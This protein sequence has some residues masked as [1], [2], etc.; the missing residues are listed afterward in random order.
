ML[1]KLV[2]AICLI[3]SAFGVCAD[4]GEYYDT[5][6]H[7]E[8][9]MLNGNDYVQKRLEELQ[10]HQAK[11]TPIEKDFYQLLSAH[12]DY[13]L[14][15]LYACKEKAKVL[16]KETNSIDIKAKA[17]ILLATAEHVLGNHVESFIALDKAVT[18]VPDL[19]RQRYKASILQAAVGIYQQAEL[20][21]FALE[22]ARNLQVEARKLKHGEYLCLANYELAMIERKTGQTKMAKQRL[23]L[24][25]EYCK[26]NDSKIFEYNSIIALNEITAELGEFEK[27]NQELKKIIQ[28]VNA[29]G[30]KNLISQ[31]NIAIARNYLGM[32]DYKE[33]EKYALVSHNLANEVG[34]KR[35][36]E[37][38]AEILA[39]AYSGMGQKEEAINYFNQ[40]MELNTQNRIRVR[41]R[42]LAYDVARQNRN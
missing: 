39:K 23:M 15:N 31:L 36:L 13:L 5:L 21:E 8:R 37:M 18:A 34:D 17:N 28:P 20:F 2:C 35:R 14:S 29:I 3:I 12:H 38:A 40:F 6:V 32:E 33:A 7:I 19:T 10:K 24:A 1:K 4:K 22:L 25:I 41:Q 11:F 16:I 26:N 27:S 42:K 9:N 30:W